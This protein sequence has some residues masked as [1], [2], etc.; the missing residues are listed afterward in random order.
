MGK[1]TLGLDSQLYQYL[2]SVSLRE[3]EVLARLRQET[4]KLPMNR[5]QISPDQGQFM[6]LLVQLIGAKKTL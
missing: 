2:L 3:P 1:T 6:S 4:A 5:M